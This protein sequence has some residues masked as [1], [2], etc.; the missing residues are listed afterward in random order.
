MALLI[1]FFRRYLMLDI[2]PSSINCTSAGVLIT[3]MFLQI[4]HTAALWLGGEKG[5][6]TSSYKSNQKPKGCTQEAITLFS[7]CSFYHFPKP[8]LVFMNENCMLWKKEYMAWL[9]KSLFCINISDSVKIQFLNMCIYVC[10]QNRYCYCLCTS[11][12]YVS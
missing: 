12:N 4:I 3:D 9:S 7:P 10:E 6:S 5:E 1:H 11:S 8:L 2:Q